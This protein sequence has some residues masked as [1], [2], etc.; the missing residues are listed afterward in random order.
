M[1]EDTQ[2]HQCLHKHIQSF[3]FEDGKPA[4]LWACAECLLKFV[5]AQAPAPLTYAQPAQAPAPLTYAQ[6]ES[7]WRTVMRTSAR[8]VPP[9]VFARAIERAHGIG[10]EVKP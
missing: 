7:M 10:A 4:P 6:I 1:N 3:K 2:P 9:A 8:D 5:P